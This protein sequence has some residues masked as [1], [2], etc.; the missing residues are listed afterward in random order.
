MSIAILK[1]VTQTVE[2]Q[3]AIDNYYRYGKLNNS[4]LLTL[5]PN[6]TALILENDCK[7]KGLSFDFTPFKK[8]QAAMGVIAATPPH[9]S[10]RELVANERA[11]NSFKTDYVAA[12]DNVTILFDFKSHVPVK[13][14]QK[15]LDLSQAVL[16]CETFT[17]KSSVEI[18]IGATLTRVECESYDGYWAR[19]AGGYTVSAYL[20]SGYSSGKRVTKKHAIY[21]DS[22]EKTC[23]DDYIASNGID[24][25]SFYDEDNIENGNQSDDF[26]EWERNYLDDD[27]L[28]Q[29]RCY[30]DSDDNVQID[31]AVSYND[32]PYYRTFETIADITLD[33]DK[34]MTTKNEAILRLF[35]LKFNKA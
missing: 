7:D 17:E 25:T 20:S 32:A 35:Q 4:L 29:F 15:M 3:A 27:V 1:S 2:V 26:S 14:R 6:L 10:T 31:F 23:V 24:E 22:L 33:C 21:Y 30:I 13:L 12:I 5:T 9:T 28:S 8:L 11:K 34:F 16:D 18:V 19:N